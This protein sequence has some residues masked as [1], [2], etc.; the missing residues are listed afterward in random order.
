MMTSL[1]L[2]LYL[3]M[4]TPFL[5]DASHYL[6]FDVA[7][8]VGIWSWVLLAS[9]IPF[10]SNAYGDAGVWCWIERSGQAY[11]W[12]LFYIPMFIQIIAV[13]VLYLLVIRTLNMRRN[14][15]TMAQRNKR[16]QVKNRLMGY[17]L[18]FIGC[19][20][21]PIIHR[22]YDAVPTT[23]ESFALMLLQSITAPVFGF[24]IAVAFSFE[25]NSWTRS[26]GLGFTRVRALCCGDGN[27]PQENVTEVP[28]QISQTSATDDTPTV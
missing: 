10:A 20:I 13:F 28:Q 6:W 24:A 21:F 3:T 25:M 9:C 5:F 11:R 23:G 19:Y 14:G 27:A 2:N 1:G 22:I 16:D 17:P 15:I 7:S 18:I 8:H 12:A 26:T 4:A